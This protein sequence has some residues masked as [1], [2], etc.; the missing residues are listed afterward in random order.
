MYIMVS[1][2]SIE[3]KQNLSENN[4]KLFGDSLSLSISG[5]LSWRF[6]ICLR[7]PDGFFSI[8][9][10]LFGSGGASSTPMAAGIWLCYHTFFSSA[11][12]GF[13]P[14]VLPGW[15]ISASSYSSEPSPVVLIIDCLFL[16]SCRVE[17]TSSFFQS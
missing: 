8:G 15:S 2:N 4:K 6:G 7:Q 5:V 12:S 13:S 9:C 16:L 1:N 3:I 17:A 11:D 10:R 14:G